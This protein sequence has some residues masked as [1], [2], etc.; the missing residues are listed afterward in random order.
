M[1]VKAL[2]AEPYHYIF[3]TIFITVH[4]NWSYAH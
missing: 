2:Q 4:Q 1:V 3:I